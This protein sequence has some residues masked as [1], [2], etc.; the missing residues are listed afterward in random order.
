M[1]WH[2]WANACFRF[3]LYDDALAR[4]SRALTLARQLTAERP[5]LLGSTL[6]TRG[7]ILKGM[8]RDALD[9]GRAAEAAR[10]D[11]QVEATYQECL[12]AQT[13]RDT[14]QGRHFRAVVWKQIGVFN[15]ERKR[16]AYADDAY[17]R[18][19]TLQPDLADVYYCR[20]LNQAQWGADEAQARR[21][22]T[23]IAHFRQARIYA[24]TSVGMDYPIA[25]GL[26]QEIEGALR[27]LGAQ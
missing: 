18:A 15:N 23:G 14:T 9:Q 5:D 10:I 11:E 8:G 26:L 16:Y 20:A 22:D 17:A 4:N 13:T 25:L 27:R 6:L 12:G 24:A 7:N 2:Q 19:I 21:L 1:H 3:R